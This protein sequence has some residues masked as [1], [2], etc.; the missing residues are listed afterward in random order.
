MKR[1]L[2]GIIFLTLFTVSCAALNNSQ[3]NIDSCLQELEII[4]M[5]T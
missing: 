3:Q 4:D 5:F 2:I 1:G